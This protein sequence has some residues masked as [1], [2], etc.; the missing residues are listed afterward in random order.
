[1]RLKYPNTQSCLLI[2]HSECA[3][4]KST[5]ARIFPHFLA[6]STT[7]GSMPSAGGSFGGFGGGSGGGGFGGGGF[8]PFGGMGGSA[9]GGG[10]GGGG[11]SSSSSSSSS[12]SGPGSSSSAST[13]S[14]SSGNSVTNNYYYITSGSGSKPT[15]S[16]GMSTVTGVQV[17]PTTYTVECRTEEICTDMCGG[18]YELGEYTSDGCRECVCPPKHQYVYSESMAINVWVCMNEVY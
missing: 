2:F 13:G 9:P 10:G 3:I 15:G 17:P 11:G 1:M 8:S 12:G 6:G 18:N 5:P 16:S 14:G 7:G 4:T